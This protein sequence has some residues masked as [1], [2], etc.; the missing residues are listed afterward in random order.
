LLS[1]IPTVTGQT[2]NHL[3][4]TFAGLLPYQSRSIN[5]TFHV[6]APPV[7]NI[8]DVLNFT[9]IIEPVAG[10]EAPW[11]NKFDLKQIVRGSFDPNDKLVTEGA[12]LHISK[13]GDYLHYIVRFQNTGNAAAASVIIKD[14]LAANLDWSSFA[15]ID[16]SHSS[17]TVITKGNKVEFIFENI[18]L[19][20]MATNE[21]ASHGFVSFKIKPKSTVT[22]GETISNKAEIYFDYNLPVVTNTAV[23]TIV[24]SKQ[25]DDPIDL[26]IFS[27][28]V[29][30][31]IRFTVKAGSTIKAINLYNTVGAKL[32]S[33]T[34]TGPGTDR[35]VKTTGLPNGI[36][37]LEVIT[38]DGTAVKK[39]IV[40]K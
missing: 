18:N 13:I 36:I 8:G 16:A 1:A 12:S 17:R 11:D 20:S 33:E 27:N 25:P 23:I 31:E 9:A 28:P 4:W 21:P 6:N 3:S 10:D 35:T 30:D 2:P 22:V 39:A 40:V 7:V 5:L 14:S 37:F 19:P 26:R 15:P 29:R 32:Y 24:T 34:V 38:T